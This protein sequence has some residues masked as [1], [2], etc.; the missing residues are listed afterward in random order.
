MIEFHDRACPVCGSTDTSKEFAASTYDEAKLTTLSFAARKSPESMW[1]RL[2]SCP[3]CQLIYASPAPKLTSLTTAYREADYDSSAESQLASFTYIHYLSPYL[4][5]LPTLN[6]A[7]DVGTGDG[8]FLERL[9]EKKFT[10][11]QGVE[12]SLAP[13]AKSKSHIKPLIRQGLFAAS[14]YQSNSFD[15]ISCFQTIEHVDDPLMLCQSV[16]QLLK[17]GGIL[18]MVAHN[19]RS[20]SA[21]IL[22][23]KSP[24]FDIEHLQ[25]FSPASMKYLLEKIG[26]SDIAIFPVLNKY[27]LHYWLKLL[28]FP[29]YFKTKLIRFTQ[30]IKLGYLQISIPAGNMA[31]IGFKPK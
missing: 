16:F 22:G 27:P 13:I 31:V 8:A 19:T 18:F 3:V 9:L 7:L 21:K 29:S 23:M 17:P 10:S 15:L 28:P 4:T 2:I 5:R 12:P 30:F 26:F 1:H 6:Q 24:I 14:D 11:V 25:L 20:M